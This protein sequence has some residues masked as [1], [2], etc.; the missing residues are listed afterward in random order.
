MHIVV[1]FI[2]FY[3]GIVV[4]Y[5]YNAKNVKELKK[6]KN[7]LTLENIELKCSLDEINRKG[8]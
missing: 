7:D 6:Y 2:A 3:I 5:L 8:K 1:G 4:G